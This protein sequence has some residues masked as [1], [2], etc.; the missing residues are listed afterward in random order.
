MP[1]DLPRLYLQAQRIIGVRSGNA[2]S[3]TAL[4]TEVD[5]GFRPVLDTTFPLENAADAH[6]YL[7]DGQNVGRVSLDIPQPERTHPCA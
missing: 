7:E 2:A 3:I 5:R 4:W 6:R 1:V